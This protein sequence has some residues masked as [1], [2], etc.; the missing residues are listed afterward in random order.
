MACD[1]NFSKEKMGMTKSKP[2]KSKNVK[3]LTIS[4]FGD[5]DNIKKIISILIQD[6]KELNIIDENN[7]T[8]YYLG[9]NVRIK[10]CKALD[11]T[12]GCDIAITTFNLEELHTH[13][14][15]HSFDPVKICRIFV[16]YVSRKL[17]MD[18]W[19]IQRLILFL[20]EL[21]KELRF[22]I[23]SLIDSGI[24]E[25]FNE[26]REIARSKLVMS[27]ALDDEYSVKNILLSAIKI[28]NQIGTSKLIF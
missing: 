15:I 10:N 20:N 23:M 1:F 8:F 21:P 25:K 14:V 16:G 3:D 26:I 13:L 18:C 28:S 19:P 9:K 2:K 17:I 22:I 6:K 11:M 27:V 24:S 5:S 4:F 12:C 7:A